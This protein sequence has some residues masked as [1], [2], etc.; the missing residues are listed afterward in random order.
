MNE[1]LIFVSKFDDCFSAAYVV[2]VEGSAD[3]NG[4]I[5]HPTGD[6]RIWRAQVE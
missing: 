3:T 1:I 6:M 2:H 4:S 5:V